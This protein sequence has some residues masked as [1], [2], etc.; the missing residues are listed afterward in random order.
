MRFLTAKSAKCFAKNA[1]VALRSLRCLFFALFAVNS[2]FNKLILQIH[3]ERHGNS[4]K[5]LGA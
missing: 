4:S 2:S 1:K 3:D 5:I